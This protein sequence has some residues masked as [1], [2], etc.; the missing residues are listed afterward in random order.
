M[1]MIGKYI[2][3]ALMLIPA[4]VG[5]QMPVPQE[6][7][8]VIPSPLPIGAY[9]TRFFIEGVG[10]QYICTNAMNPKNDKFTI[11]KE[12]DKEMYERIAAMKK[13]Q[14]LAGN[15]ITKDIKI[16]TPIF[17]VRPVRAYADAA[18]LILGDVSGALGEARD[19]LAEERVLAAVLGMTPI[20][21]AL[22]RNVSAAIN[23][24]EDIGG[25]SRRLPPATQKKLALDALRELE[26]SLRAALESIDKAIAKM[27]AYK[28]TLE[29]LIRAEELAKTNIALE[30]NRENLMGL[31]GAIAVADAMR[32]AVAEEAARI[33]MF[34]ALHA[35]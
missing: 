20:A 3:A 29:K 10:S 32:R 25:I 22:E 4:L 18:A 14:V 8:P 13:G 23:A 34:R 7:I 9:C 24:V 1:R 26:A 35:D 17:D 27:K 5:A 6:T 15:P 11:D 2:M 16:I 19:F 21:R 28:G 33:R 31:E 30:T 12:R